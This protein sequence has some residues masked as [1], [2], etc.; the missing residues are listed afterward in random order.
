MKKFILVVI[1]LVAVFYFASQKYGMTAGSGV[2]GKYRV[3]LVD[4]TSGKITN[5][6]GK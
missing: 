3:V 4:K 2:D 1:L 5:L 6:W